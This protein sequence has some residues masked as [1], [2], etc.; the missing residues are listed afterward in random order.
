VAKP[1]DDLEAAWHKLAQQRDA[2]RGGFDRPL[3]DLVRAAEATALR[4]FYPFTS[5]AR[6]CFAETRFPYEGVQ[7]GYIEF[8]PGGRFVVYRG[9]PHGDST[10]WLATENADTAVATL[11][12]L[13]GSP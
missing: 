7:P 2:L 3:A 1:D 6:L 5:M 9:L 4:S 10:A 8:Y 13:L 12:E 11:V